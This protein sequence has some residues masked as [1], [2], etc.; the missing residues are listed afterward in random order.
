[1]LAGTRTRDGGRNTTRS[2]T[3]P[4]TDHL[5]AQPTDFDVVEAVDHVAQARDVPAAQVALAWVLH[6]PGVSAPI[7]GSTKEQHL[8]D[9]LAAEQLTLGDDE[10]EALEKPYVAHPVLGHF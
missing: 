8:L 2:S 10:I 3:D 7:V 4:F 6:K 9:A 5:Y 1:V